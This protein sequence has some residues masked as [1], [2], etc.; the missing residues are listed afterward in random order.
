ML[1]YLK[2][3]LGL[4]NPK[5]SLC[6][7]RA[8][9][10]AP[11]PDQLQ[12]PRKKRKAEVFE[13]LTQL[14]QN[15]CEV[16]YSEVALASWIPKAQFGFSYDMIR[17]KEEQLEDARWAE[18]KLKSMEE[19]GTVDK[20]LGKLSKTSV[21]DEDPENDGIN[22][23]GENE[24]VLEGPIFSPPQEMALK[25]LNDAYVVSQRAQDLELSFS[26]RTNCLMVAPSGAG[27]TF[28]ARSFAEQ[29]GVPFMGINVSSWTLIGS[30]TE[31][32]NCTL[33]R[34]AAFIAGNPDG[35]IYLDELDKID[36]DCSWN[37]HLQLEI[38]NLLDC[39]I[40][41]EVIDGLQKLAQT[42]IDE[43]VLEKINQS[44]KENFF[45]IAGGTWQEF[46]ENRSVTSVGFNSSEETRKLDKKELTKHIT[47]ELL[48]RF[49]QTRIVLTPLT[50][51]NFLMLAKKVAK[52]FG[53]HS[54]DDFT[55]TRK[56]F[57]NAVKSGVADAVKNQIGMRFLEECITEALKPKESEATLD[58]PPFSC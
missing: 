27:K 52:Q 49:Q 23:E 35:I 6:E 29:K 18:A 45:V 43:E 10:C 39:Q 42:P 30:R 3:E 50:R 31:A 58:S 24:P 47:P 53:A 4:K 20:L 11:D 33:V 32:E 15:E 28:L 41:G 14:W 57:L 55:E 12:V 2:D 46:W 34:V 44:L 26:P 5:K 21:S 40:G 1:S 37:K 25:E 9:A 19:D 17:E 56:S 16:P 22:P 54:L 38:H 7:C 36:S 51:E 48:Q 8:W 13:T